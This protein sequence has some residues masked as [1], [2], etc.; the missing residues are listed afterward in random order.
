[1]DLLLEEYREGIGCSIVSTPEQ[2]K[3]SEVR[4]DEIIKKRFLHHEPTKSFVQTEPDKEVT[5]ASG[6]R[7]TYPK[8]V[9]FVQPVSLGEILFCCR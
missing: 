8:D 7:G 5:S 6:C 3:F 4:F 1:M 9:H 2:M